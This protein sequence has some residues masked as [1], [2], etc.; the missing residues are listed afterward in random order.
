MK[1]RDNTS[2]HRETVHARALSAAA[3][4]ARGPRR[5]VKSLAWVSGTALMMLAC[6]PEKDTGGSLETSDTQAESTGVE[7]ETETEATTSEGETLLTD[8]TDAGTQTGGMSSV[9]TDMTGMT[10]MMDETDSE[11]TTI[12]TTEGETELETTQGDT[13]ETESTTAD[14]LDDCINDLGEV[15]WTCCEEQNWEPQPQC[16][17]WGPPAPPSAR[18]VSPRVMQAL[19]DAMDRRLV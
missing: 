12:E 15:D 18:V 1:S 13:G 8:A 7:T 19:A 3:G 10:T 17:P 14:D 4:L 11:A 6:M 9:T 16:T 2:S 5:R